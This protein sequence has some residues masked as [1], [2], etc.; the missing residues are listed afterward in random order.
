[1]SFASG[2]IYSQKEPQQTFTLSFKFIVKYD[3]DEI[4]I[5]MCY[6]YTFTDMIYFLEC[7]APLKPPTEFIEK[8]INSILRRAPLCKTTAGNNLD[9]LI[10][11]NFMSS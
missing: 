11:T 8:R 10:I 6:P 5:A 9:M 1:M 2:A 4:Y 3:L 7:I